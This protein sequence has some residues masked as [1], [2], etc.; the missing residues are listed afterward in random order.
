MPDCPAYASLRASTLL[1]HLAVRKSLKAYNVSCSVR[2]M[3]CI[4]HI[5]GDSLLRLSIASV[6]MARLS[7]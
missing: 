3:A 7:L 4:L 2:S 1:R 5:L 6:M